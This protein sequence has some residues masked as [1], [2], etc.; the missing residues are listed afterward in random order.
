NLLKAMQV[1][2]YDAPFVLPLIEDEELQPLEVP[3]K[4]AYSLKSPVGSSVS[5]E[6]KNA[7]LTTVQALQDL[8]HQTE[9][10]TPETDGIKA[11]QTYYIVNGVETA[12]MM[13]GIESGMD[14]KVTVEDMEPMSWALYRSG[15]NITGVD[16]SKV[17]AFWDQLTAAMER[18]FE[19]YDA[20]ILPA[21]NGPAF[22]H[23][24]FERSPELIE[25]LKNMDAFDPE[26]QQQL[27]W[28]MF[29]E[30][31]V[32]TPFTQQQNLTGQPA[33]SLPMYENK[34]GYPVGT[35]IWTKKGAETL[36]LQI[37]KQL[38]EQGQL[39]TQIVEIENQ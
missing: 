12:V 31:L 17:L 10:K 14:R 19:R 27:I 23:N 38:E 37:A 18:F 21:T 8:G 6:A 7:V 16:Y 4:F 24:H 34:E 13:E 26:T 1:E 36:L 2:Q 11:M 5:E 15:L 20:L 22:P 30:S 25:Q 35:Q 33:I 32:Y 9:E 3:L 39:D 29:E 28:E